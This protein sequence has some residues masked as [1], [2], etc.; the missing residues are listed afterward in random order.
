MYERRI[1]T[2][3]N[4]LLFRA[5]QF[6]NHLPG[7][8]GF[9]RR[10]G[11]GEGETVEVEMLANQILGR[12]LSFGNTGLPVIHALRQHVVNF[13]R[14]QS[15]ERPAKHLLTPRPWHSG[16][17]IRKKPTHR[18]AIDRGERKYPAVGNCAGR[19]HSEIFPSKA[20][21]RC[22]RVTGPLK[23]KYDE[24]PIHAGRSVPRA[25]PADPKASASQKGGEIHLQLTE[26]QERSIAAGPQIKLYW[27]ITGRR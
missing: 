1:N 2:H 6:L 4:P 10:H 15:R 18:I 24:I 11:L 19:Q 16:Q 12:D 14:E 13:V 3:Y 20:R 7:I 23:I 9:F 27:W 17:R 5:V 26:N 22:P 8:G 25:P 21:N